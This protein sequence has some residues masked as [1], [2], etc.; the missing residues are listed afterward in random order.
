MP[1]RRTPETALAQI[2]GL[3]KV[4]PG[5]R[6]DVERVALDG[7]DLTVHSGD[8]LAVVGQSGSGKTTLARILSGVES[9]TDGQVLLG[10]EDFSRRSIKRAER[11]RRARLVQMVF[12]DHYS[13]LDQRQ[14]VASAVE[15]MLA[16]HMSGSRAQ[17]RA[18][19]TSLLNECGLD[20]R[21]LTAYPRQLSGGQRQ[22][23]AIA[24]ALAA[25]P[26]LLVLDEAVSALDVSV[27]AQILNLLRALREQEGLTYIFITHNLGVARQIS[28]NCIVLHRGVIVE[29][30]KTA[31]VLQ[32]PRH[33]YTQELIAAV[34][35]PGWIPRR[36]RPAETAAN[37]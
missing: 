16:E 37:A 18:R 9:A 4:Y 8:S 17:R 34:P 36:R 23:V 10:G 12:Q 27:Q 32:T 35:R 28:E 2:A 22:R 3:R 6:G 30:G 21:V 29:R 7:I 1:E 11:R 13:S 20:A 19:V 5:G 26:R 15:E 33:A 25:Q 14:T 24:K 31:A